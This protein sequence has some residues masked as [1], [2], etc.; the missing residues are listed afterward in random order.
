MSDNK[1][2]LRQRIKQQHSAHLQAVKA[3][4]MK[5]LSHDLEGHTAEKN[6]AS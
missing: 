2:K 5:K 1:H 3:R 6:T 4:W